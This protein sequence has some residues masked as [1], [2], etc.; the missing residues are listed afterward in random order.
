MKKV[1]SILAV[2]LMAMGM[3]SCENDA[4]SNDELYDSLEIMANDE[5][6]TEHSQ[7][8]GGNY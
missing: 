7:G 4:A 3:V 8:S 1:A 5:N 6:G 2:V